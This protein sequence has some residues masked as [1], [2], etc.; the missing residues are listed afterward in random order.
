[1]A[2]WSKDEE[3]ETGSTLIPVGTHIC[4]L[5]NC[6]IDTTKDDYTL[7]LTWK[8][9][10]GESQGKVRK[11]W[12]TFREG[13]KRWIMWQTGVMGISEFIRDCDT[14]NQAALKAADILFKGVNKLNVTLEVYEDTY[15]DRTGTLKT[16]QKVKLIERYEGEVRKDGLPNM[17]PPPKQTLD[18]ELPF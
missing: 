11:Q 8:V 13:G 2:L 17:A 6:T 15:T 12:I 4:T 18:E 5:E 10:G 16:S 7:E 9:L 1:M 14:F 3:N